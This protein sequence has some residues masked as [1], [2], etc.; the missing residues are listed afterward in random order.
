MIERASIMDN[1]NLLR[2]DAL[3]AYRLPTRIGR[4]L[5]AQLLP[6]NTTGNSNYNY[7]NITIIIENTQCLLQVTGTK[8]SSYG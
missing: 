7:G 8:I 4:N 5:H 3:Q 1:A 6:S 2:D